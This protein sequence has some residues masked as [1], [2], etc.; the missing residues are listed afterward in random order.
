MF[1]QVICA[2]LMIM[3]CAAVV[4]NYDVISS[5]KMGGT[6]KLLLYFIG[7]KYVALRDAKIQGRQ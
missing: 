6:L 2:E 5:S 7:E 4:S 1:E 3:V